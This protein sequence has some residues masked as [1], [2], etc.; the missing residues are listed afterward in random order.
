M[1][2]EV[3]VRNAPSEKSVLLEKESME[4]YHIYWE[5]AVLMIAIPK[6]EIFYAQ[7][8]RKLDKQRNRFD[9]TKDFK[10]IDD[11]FTKIKI[12]DLE[13]YKELTHCIMSD[14]YSLEH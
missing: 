12:Q 3:K 10:K 13:Y 9:A 6:G 4:P 7:Y 2:V 1:L 8:I 5:D 14:F 11:V